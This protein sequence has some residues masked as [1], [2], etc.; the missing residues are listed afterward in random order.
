MAEAGNAGDF[1]EGRVINLTYLL[2][3]QSQE[4]GHYFGA[5]ARGLLCL[6]G[7]RHRDIG[8]WHQAC[9]CVCVCACAVSRP[10]RSPQRVR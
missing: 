3:E 4:M 9:V 2:L 1:A 7:D 6:H 10:Y 5:V 8:R